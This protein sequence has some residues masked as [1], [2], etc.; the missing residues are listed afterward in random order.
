MQIHAATLPTAPP[1]RAPARAPPAR[2]P[3]ARAPPVR[4]KP[5][6]VITLVLKLLNLLRLQG[7][8]SDLPYAPGMLILLSAGYLVLGMGSGLPVATLLALLLVH[9]ALLFGLLWCRSRT[10]RF[11]QTA[12]AVVGIALLL[13]LLIWPPIAILNLMQI[14]TSE[15]AH[16]FVRVLSGVLLAWMVLAEANVVRQAADLPWVGAIP[17]VLALY[18]VNAFILQQG[19]P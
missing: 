18:L 7:S 4:A 5:I 19:L 10:G 12:L 16:Q 6:R 15:M 11:V 13:E 14:G 17:A 8:A 2:A 3:P 1:V 9:L